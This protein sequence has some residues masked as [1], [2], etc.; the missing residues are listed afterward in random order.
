MK[1][2]DVLCVEWDIYTLAYSVTIFTIRH[3]FTLSLHESFPQPTGL[4]TWTFS[5]IFVVI[6]LFRPR[7]VNYPSVFERTLCST[8]SHR[9]SSPSVRLR[10]QHCTVVIRLS[11]NSRVTWAVQASCFTSP[12]GFSFPS[13]AQLGVAWSLQKTLLYLMYASGLPGCSVCYTLSH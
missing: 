6:F 10:T 4:L 13:L 2:I 12:A 1:E 7:P 5:Q 9:I 3:L 8:L 11:F